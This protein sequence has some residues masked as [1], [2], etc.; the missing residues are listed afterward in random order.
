MALAW[1]GQA[2]NMNPLQ[3]KHPY[4]DL[5]IRDGSGVSFEHWIDSRSVELHR[6][7]FFEIILIE[8]G[9]CSHIYQNM[10]T[11]LI[12]GDAVVVPPHNAHAFS[13]SAVTSIFLC[14][15]QESAIQPD[16]LQLLGRSPVQKGS[17]SNSSTQAEEPE[18]VWEHLLADKERYYVNA[19]TDT[20]MYSLNSS[21]QGV[22]HLNPRELSFVESLFHSMFE[23]RD[24]DESFFVLKKKAFSEVILLELHQALQRQRLIYKTHSGSREVAVADVLMF[25]EQNLAEPL[26]FDML[27]KKFGFSTNHFRKLFRDATGLSPVKYVNRL[28]ITQA[29]EYMK[30]DHL[31]ARE[32]AELV[33]FIDMNYFSRIFKQVMGCSPSRL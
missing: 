30:R 8:K 25:I 5:H 14:Q 6:H 3:E 22:I 16:I 13:L 26:D 12:P 10:Q 21:K 29:C 18:P 19:K 27:A 23:D 2:K 28:R 31:S 15:F 20:D 9:S 32:A 4:F 7:G 17:P 33:G 11:M 24:L 1:K